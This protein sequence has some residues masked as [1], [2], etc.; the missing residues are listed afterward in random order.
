MQVAVKDQNVTHVDIKPIYTFCD[1][2]QWINVGAASQ[3]G[4]N[5]KLSSF[6]SHHTNSFSHIIIKFKNKKVSSFFK[7]CGSLQ[8]PRWYILQIYHFATN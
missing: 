6:R 4:F 3:I 2:S 8:Q 7:I 1:K 5:V